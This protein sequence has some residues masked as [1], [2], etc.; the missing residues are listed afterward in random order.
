MLQLPLLLP[1]SYGPISCVV[2][3]ITHFQQE[4]FQLF[5]YVIVCMEWLFELQCHSSSR[6]H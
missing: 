2:A 1:K 3:C 5:Y 6:L 4:F